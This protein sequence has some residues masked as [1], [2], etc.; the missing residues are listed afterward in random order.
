MCQTDP[1]LSYS[2]YCFLKMKAKSYIYFQFL[3]LTDL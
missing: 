1:N 2:I 3:L